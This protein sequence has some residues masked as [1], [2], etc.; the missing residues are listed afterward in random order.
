ME[1]RREERKGEGGR[2]KSI[3]SSILRKE[4]KGSALNAPLLAEKRMG[5]V[6]RGRRDGGN[7]TASHK[8]ALR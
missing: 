6:I 5:T 1:D 2:E 4:G 7:Y 3:A 8:S